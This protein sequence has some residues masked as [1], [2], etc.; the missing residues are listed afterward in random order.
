V[1]ASGLLAMIST[2]RRACLRRDRLLAALESG[3]HRIHDRH[4]E[5]IRQ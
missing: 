3:F 2:S 5:F 1:F 4:I